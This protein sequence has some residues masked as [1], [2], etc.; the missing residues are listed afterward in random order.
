MCFSESWRDKDIVW[1][2]EASERDKLLGTWE[3]MN[4]LPWRD[5]AG[6]WE[7]GKRQRETL[8]PLKAFLKSKPDIPSHILKLISHTIS[9]LD[10]TQE[11]WETVSS[12]FWYKFSPSKYF[13]RSWGHLPQSFMCHMRIFEEWS[14]N[15]IIQSAF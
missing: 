8:D 6:S 2:S 15:E 10:G 11:F 14:S 4:R 5:G 1:N 13:I 3:M 7:L 12:A 9:S